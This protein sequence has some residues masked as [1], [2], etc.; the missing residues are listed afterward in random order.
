MRNGAAMGRCVS[1]VVAASRVARMNRSNCMVSAVVVSLLF[2]AG[3]DTAQAQARL[4]V[5]PTTPEAALTCVAARYEGEALAV[6]WLGRE[7]RWEVRWLTR[8]RAVLRIKLAPGC[9]FDEVEGVGQE[10]A[11]KRPVGGT[12]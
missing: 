4:F 7:Q 6:Q 1:V 9:Q 5:A 11:L 12:R 8:A 3:A 2:L 10:P